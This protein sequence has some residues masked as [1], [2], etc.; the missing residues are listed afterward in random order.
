ML[1]ISPRKLPQT[2]TFGTSDPSIQKSSF[3]YPF[4]N[5]LSNKMNNGIANDQM[6][7]E[8]FSGFK[9]KKPKPLKSA[10][11]KQQS[12]KQHKEV[13]FAENIKAIRFIP[14]KFAEENTDFTDEEQKHL[15][16]IATGNQQQ[17]LSFFSSIFQ[18]ITNQQLFFQATTIPTL[19]SYTSLENNSLNYH[20]KSQI[21]NSEEYII[22]NQQ[23]QNL[24]SNVNGLDKTENGKFILS[25]NLNFETLI[26]RINQNYV[27]SIE[28]FIQKTFLN[29]KTRNNSYDVNTFQDI[30]INIF[31]TLDYP[32]PLTNTNIAI[33]KIQNTIFTLIQKQIK[34]NKQ[35]AIELVSLESQINQLSTGE[36]NFK[37]K[38]LTIEN[39]IRDTSQGNTSKI[40]NIKDQIDTLYKLLNNNVE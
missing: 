35:I 18:P 9:D 12:V 11:N 22:N 37:N 36:L 24:I 32:I 7:I 31:K 6:I 27:P 16:N 2:I 38:V 8:S 13:K 29:I 14:N 33:E 21:N 15:Q 5:T 1:S 25:Y 30:Y 19:N 17:Q 28:L 3:F 23:K 10:L 40:K 34:M 26:N 39:L 4:S 20:D